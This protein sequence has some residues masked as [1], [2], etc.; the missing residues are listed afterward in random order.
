[1]NHSI[2]RS[3]QSCFELYFKGADG[4]PPICTKFNVYGDG[5]QYTAFYQNTTALNEAIKQ[6]SELFGVHEENYGPGS[7][8][9]FTLQSGV[10]AIAIIDFWISYLNKYKLE[11]GSTFFEKLDE[12]GAPLQPG[13]VVAEA[14]EEFENGIEAIREKA[15]ASAF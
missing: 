11:S 13:S 15:Y 4:H 6:A 5:L 10:N 3:V 2:L 7:I 9:G 12:Y 8:C 14:I 1:M